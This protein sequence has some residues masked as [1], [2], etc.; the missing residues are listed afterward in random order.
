MQQSTLHAKRMEQV[1]WLFNCS[2][3]LLSVTIL[4]SELSKRM[5]ELAISS[6]ALCSGCTSPMRR[7]SNTSPRLSG[8]ESQLM[9]PV[10][11]LL[12]S[13]QPHLHSP[14]LVFSPRFALAVSGP[15]DVSPTYRQNLSLPHAYSHYMLCLLFCY[16][17]TSSCRNLFM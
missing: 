10:L 17:I 5:S 12:P 4:E 14:N 11:P 1:A 13:T 7:N 16:I 6:L 2:M 8:H 3:F 9:F 15:R